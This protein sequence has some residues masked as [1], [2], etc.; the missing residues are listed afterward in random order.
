MVKV[1]SEIADRHDLSEIL[2]TSE[3][4]RTTANISAEK[5]TLLSSSQTIVANPVQSQLFDSLKS[6][7]EEIPFYPDIE[8]SDTNTKSP[9][10]IVYKSHREHLNKIK[11]MRETLSS[12]K[13]N[14]FQKILA[15]FSLDVDY[16][17]DAIDEMLAT[18]LDKMQHKST[19]EQQVLIKEFYE[20]TR[21]N[22]DLP[23]T[24]KALKKYSWIRKING[25]ITRHITKKFSDARSF[26]TKLAL[27]VVKNNR[28]KELLI[29]GALNDIEHGHENLKDLVT[30]YLPEGMTEE[31]IHEIFEAIGE[32]A[33]EQAID[34]M[35]EIKNGDFR[36]KFAD[37]VR[38]KA[39]KIVET[40]RKRTKEYIK[41]F[42]ESAKGR[43]VKRVVERAYHKV[44]N[45]KNEVSQCKEKTNKAI[46]EVK[47]KKAESEEAVEKAKAEESKARNI[48]ESCGCKNL[49][50]D[51]LYKFVK[52]KSP[53]LAH[54]FSE[55]QENRKKAYW[56]EY[57]AKSAEKYAML[58]ESIANNHLQ[59]E[60]NRMDA[61][62]ANM[63][64]LMQMPVG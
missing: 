46:L 20:N 60:Q 26:N 5:N 33:D 3:A 28:E 52:H 62:I 36:E 45:A 34:I 59:F 16:E 39:N 57:D 32:F 44:Q 1:V 47:I 27:S 40:A 10:K 41:S 42:L 54:D 48:A 56:A 58:L 50:N 6:T 15:F 37:M 38:R 7:D 49:D 63:Q 17:D 9:E 13:T 29:N 30:K 24:E 21:E 18:L 8:L 64:A 31:Q 25:G 53:R 51:S 22:I 11:L 2:Q 4:D 14:F 12:N 43:T 23:R 19:E 55:A 35:E 61:T